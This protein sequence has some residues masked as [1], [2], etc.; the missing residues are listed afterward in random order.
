M[1]QA[2]RLGLRV[3]DGLSQHLAKLSLDYISS[4]VERIAKFKKAFE[5]R[6]KK[7]DLSQ[8][9]GAEPQA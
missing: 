4:L 1:R 9:Q 8:A 2:L 6:I 5:P 3:A 7:L